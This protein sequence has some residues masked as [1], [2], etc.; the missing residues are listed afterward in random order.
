MS[1]A[2]PRERW[3]QQIPLAWRWTCRILARRQCAGL[4]PDLGYYSP[5]RNAAARELAARLVRIERRMSDAAFRALYQGDC[6]RR[7]GA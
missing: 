1:N 5:V 7:G 2:Y 4:I 6:W 3:A